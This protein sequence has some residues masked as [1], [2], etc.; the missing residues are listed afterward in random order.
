MNKKGF[1]HWN[2]GFVNPKKNTWNF[3]I[4]FGFFSDFFRIFFS[5]F[6]L[7]VRSFFWVNNPSTGN[8]VAAG[9]HLNENEKWTETGS[10]TDTKRKWNPVQL[11]FVEKSFSFPDDHPLRVLTC[12]LRPVSKGGE[13]INSSLSCHPDPFSSVNY[14]IKMAPRVRPRPLIHQLRR[15]ISPFSE[16]IKSRRGDSLL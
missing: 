12:V 14:S 5:D 6:F 8:D 7:G 11:S 15:S 4:F 1:K 10:V 16:E 3:W 13:V 9:R 2:R